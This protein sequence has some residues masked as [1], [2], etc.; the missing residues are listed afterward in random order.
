M[1]LLNILN[2]V[3]GLSFIMLVLSMIVT[4]ICQFISSAINSKGANLRD[5][6]ADLLTGV[7]ASFT[8]AE[9]QA[10]ATG[11][12]N[13]PLIAD[14]HW[15]GSRRLG[16]V[17]QREELNELLLELAAGES[18]GRLEAAVA[19]KL[20]KVL[21]Q[22]GIDDPAGALA[23]VRASAM[24]LQM[25]QP[26]V[27]AAKQ[28]AKALYLESAPLAA[29]INA[30]FDR[31]MARV[32]ER[33]TLSM[34]AW[35][36]LAALVVAWSLQ[37]DTIALVNRLGRDKDFQAKVA[38]AA[39]SYIGKTSAPTAPVEGGP[40]PSSAQVQAAV[41]DA[42]ALYGIDVLTLPKSLPTQWPF[43]FTPGVLASALLLSLGAPFWYNVLKDAVR[44]RSALSAKDDKER[45]ERRSEQT[46]ADAVPPVAAVAA[47]TPAGTV[48]SATLANPDPEGVV[49]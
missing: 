13:H 4:V 40:P 8:P 31:I 21:E 15:F 9:R 19:T 38:D 16:T 46:Q 14:M 11:L 25:A 7:S 5:G 43:G 6:L 30:G 49:G 12:L 23:S 33:F 37:V 3:I 20:K 10:I 35:T 27:A 28:V 26:E 36:V 24:Q 44:F 32:A 42:K 39:V 18:A 29:S 45:E 41:Q 17:I 1:D 47:V 48:S 2:V 34:R 22:Y